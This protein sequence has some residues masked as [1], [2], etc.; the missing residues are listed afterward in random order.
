MCHKIRIIVQL[1]FFYHAIL[2]A[3]L[4]YLCDA[5]LNLYNERF[6]TIRFLQK[7]WKERIKNTALLDKQ[8]LLWLDKFICLKVKL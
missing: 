2:F 4:E 8:V 5:K 6:Y 3:P 7:A 1:N